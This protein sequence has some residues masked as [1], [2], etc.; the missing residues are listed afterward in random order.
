MLRRFFSRVLIAF[1]VGL[2]LVFT[3]ATAQT[4]E[5][6]LNPDPADWPTYGRDLTMTRYSPLDQINRDN[7]G[8]L[9]L[10]WGY[11]FDLDSDAQFS[12]V[13]Y[14]GTMYVN[15]PDRVV[16]LDGANGDLV[17]E[18]VVELNENTNFLTSGR[19]RGSVVVYEGKVFTTLGDGRVVGLDAGTGDELWSTQVGNIEL[20]EGFSSGPIFADG[21]IIVG[22][23]GADI[24]G[25]PGRISAMDTESGEILW[26][27]NTVPKPGEPGFETWDPPSSAEWGGGSAWNVGA[28]DPET[29]TVIYGVGQPIPWGNLDVRGTPSPDLYTASWVALDVETGELKWY[30]QAVP[31]DEW[32]Y[33]QI[34][35]PTI[36][37]LEIDGQTRRTAI[38]P[39]TTG[40]IVLVDVETGEFL[41]AH[42][43]HPDTSPHTGYEEDGT[44]II[45]DSKRITEAGQTV[46]VCPGIRWV[47]FEPAGFSPET[48]LYYRPNVFECANF[49]GYGLPEGWQPGE[50]PIE[51]DIE[52]LSDEF[53]RLGALSAIDPVTGEVVWEF[54]SGYGVRSGPVVTAG[55]LVFQGFPDRRFRAFDAETGEVLW[56]QPVTAYIAAN[57]ITYEVDGKQYVAVPVGGTGGLV[58]SRQSDQP[59]LVTSDVEMFVFALPDD[60]AGQTGGGDEDN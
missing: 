47:D 17:W 2:P 32:D 22:P 49:T 6:L 11:S 35:T 18:Y 8:E 21:K 1:I 55:G 43:M 30:H 16:A 50:G 29:G 4:A 27:F 52:G 37:D 12:P 40:F 39:T 51:V 20:G 48:G 15:L 13:V 34:A 59:A 26:T 53:D 14:D 7:V 33:D 60:L 31:S 9:R 46:R 36:A 19:S 57:P 45:D 23:S 3:S 38:L 25:V 56:E 24:G 10:T 54:P 41:T 42:Q 58:I 28:F 5:E 44:P